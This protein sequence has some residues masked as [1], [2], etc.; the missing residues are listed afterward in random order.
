MNSPRLTTP[1]AAA[2]PWPWLWLGLALLAA[3]VVAFSPVERT[4]GA[5]IRWVYVH[6]ALT[7]TGLTGLALAAG[8][9]GWVAATGRAAAL[10]W[11]R[12]LLL[13]GLA[14]FAAGAAMSVLAA[15]VN[16]GGI[17]LDE[18]RMTANLQI[19]AAGVGVFL[20]APGLRG[21]RW[22]GLALVGL[23][24][25]GWLALSFTPLVLHPRSPIATS[26]S[27]AIQATFAVLFA[28][29]ALA[30]AGLVL[31]ARVYLHPLDS[32]QGAS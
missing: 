12:A 6:V 8:V 32:Q 20:L 22:Q 14:F 4:L 15:W 1:P 31:R 16:W 7:W 18:P 24:V 2:W 23:L 29:C 19:L 13:V 27:P 25:F 17:A 9:G 26:T 3:G 30:A 28:L 10:P 21:P 11:A 5:G